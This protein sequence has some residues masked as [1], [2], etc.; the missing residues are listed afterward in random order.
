MICYGIISQ[1]GDGFLHAKLIF[2][3]HFVTCFTNFS[4]ADVAP[5]WVSVCGRLSAINVF[6]PCGFGVNLWNFLKS[7]RIL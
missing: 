2:S 5:Q 7:T 3:S 4:E 6:W 1:L